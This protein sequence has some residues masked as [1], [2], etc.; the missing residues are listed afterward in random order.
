MHPPNSSLLPYCTYKVIACL[1]SSLGLFTPLLLNCQPFTLC[2]TTASLPYP[3][4]GID[5]HATLSLAS[6]F[7]MQ[8]STQ[9]PDNRPVMSDSHWVRPYDNRKARV[10]GVWEWK[11]RPTTSRTYCDAIV[12]RGHLWI[13]PPNQRG[14]LLVDP[15]PRCYLPRN[16]ALKYDQQHRKR[17]ANRTRYIDH[18]ADTGLRLD[19][20]GFAEETQWWLWKTDA[21]LTAQVAEPTAMMPIMQPLPVVPPTGAPQTQGQAQMAN[22][23]IV[24]PTRPMPVPATA[25]NGTFVRVPAVE[26]R[27]LITPLPPDNESKPPVATTAQGQAAPSLFVEPRQLQ[28]TLWKFGDDSMPP[29]SPPPKASA[30]EEALQAA[31]ALREAERAGAPQEGHGALRSE[32]PI[33]RA[34]HTPEFLRMTLP[35][36]DTAED[37]ILKRYFLDRKGSRKAAKGV[38]GGELPAYFWAL[39][40]RPPAGPSARDPLLHFDL[41][42]E[43][44]SNEAAMPVDWDM[45]A[46]PL[47][48]VLEGTE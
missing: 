29:L 39:E 18:Y 23:P 47:E 31:D 42:G 13:E 32:P 9:R 15:L 40:P 16:K 41:D 34:T 3:P 46:P 30:I 17:S 20:K 6:T 8:A 24:Q 33:L 26:T 10:R 38:A 19:R 14:L 2:T 37:E 4:Q 43:P 7:T 11:R 48:E 35:V 27:Q 25:A 36:Q 44:L 1:L 45:C 22:R 12:C 28:K 5:S 21:A